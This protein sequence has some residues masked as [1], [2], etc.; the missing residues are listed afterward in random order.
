MAEMASQTQR[1]VPLGAIL[2]AGRYGAKGPDGP[3]VTLRLRHPLS[4][5]TIMARKG[6]AEALAADL[7]DGFGLALPG[8]GQSTTAQDLALRWAGPEQWLAI[9][10]G[11]RDSDLHQRLTAALADTASLVDQSQGRVAIVI[12]GPRARAVL[13][14][15]TAVDLHP[16]RFRPGQVSMTQ[17]AHVGIHL[18]QSAPDVFELLVFRSFAE[19]LFEFLTAMAAEYGYEVGS[20]E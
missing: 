13:A 18:A 14:K 10:E 19:S 5:V 11:G 2:T 17:M 12:A 6:R 16:S 20:R 9:A 8:P 3:G 1:S 7:R 4:I 15:G